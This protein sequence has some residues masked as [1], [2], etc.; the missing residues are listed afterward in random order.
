MTNGRSPSN[1]P[2]DITTRSGQ[3]VTITGHYTGYKRPWCGFI[4]QQLGDKTYKIATSW[5]ADGTYATEENALDLTSL[6]I[7]K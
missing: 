6:P 2:Y 4:D 5:N 1:F 7:P 3:V